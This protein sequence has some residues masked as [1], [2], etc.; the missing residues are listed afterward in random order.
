[1]LLLRPTWVKIII[2]AAVLGLLG[3]VIIV[4]YWHGAEPAAAT[5]RTAVLKRGDLVA[6]VSATGTIEPEEVIDVGAQV[7]GMIKE[8]GRDPNDSTRPIDYLSVVDVGTVLARIDNAV[9][10]ARLDRAAAVVE[11]AKAHVEQAQADLRRAEAN[12]LQTMAKYQQAEQD[13]ARAQK[14]LPTSAISQEEYDARQATYAVAKADLGV[15]EAAI[16][17]AKANKLAAEK[18]FLLAQAECREA[19][20]NLDYTVIRSPVKGVIVDR[21]VNVG[22]TVVS[23]LNA[24]SLFLIAKDLKRLQVWASVN[25]ADIGRL[26][27]GQAARFTVD[28]FP[29]DVFLG[30]VSQVRLNATMTQN[31][32]TYTVVV[33][34]D[35]SSGKLLPYLTANLK[36]EV[37]RRRN[38]LLAPNAALRWQPQPQQIAPDA[39]QDL[40][41]P[42][43]AEGKKT[44]DRGVVW[45][46]EKGLLRPIEVSMGLSDG[47]QTEI[48]GEGL[49][50][51]Q[52][53]VVG[54]ELAAETEGT[55][56]PFA[57]RF[58]G[59]SRR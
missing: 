54:E 21:R 36:F 42:S 9:Y 20:E 2:L 19:Q 18:A 25:E 53:V 14:L 26:H 24:P 39:R 47:I 22:Q 45:V 48:V 59:G 55:T 43:S 37:G 56:S 46:E 50:E 6:T 8:F 40:T 49:Q 5:L 35:N 10:R 27:Q 38:V 58:F 4:W 33:E 51:G 12:A 13:W 16:A 23:S 57:P 17:Q 11:R 52:P 34:T 41:V 3:G 32:V 15:S 28:A 7:V 1:M 44:H 29:D 30:Q 31:V